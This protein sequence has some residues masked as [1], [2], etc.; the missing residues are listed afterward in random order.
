[1]DTLGS[2]QNLLPAHEHVIRVGQARV[3]RGRHGIE[4]ANSKGELV[5]DVEVGAAFFENELTEVFFLWGSRFDD[6]YGIQKGRYDEI[7][8]IVSHG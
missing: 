5:E 8:P 6:Q 2:G 1:M 3:F 7:R 4:R